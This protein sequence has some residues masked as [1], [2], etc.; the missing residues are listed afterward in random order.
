M[1]GDR[2]YEMAICFRKRNKL[3]F[4]GMRTL[5]LIRRIG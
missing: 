2:A 1:L 4:L 3:K 5:S